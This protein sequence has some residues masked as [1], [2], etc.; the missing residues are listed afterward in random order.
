MNAHQHIKIVKIK[1]FVYLNT[2]TES[3]EFKYFITGFIKLRYNH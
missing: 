2:S 1:V 3:L